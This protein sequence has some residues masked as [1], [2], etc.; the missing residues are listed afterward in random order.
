MPF[1][2]FPAAW[3][4]RFVIRFTFSIGKR[5]VKASVIQVGR[6]ELISFSDALRIL[7][8]CV[9]SMTR[10]DALGDMRSFYEWRRYTDQ[11]FHPLA[12]GLDRVT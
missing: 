5:R 1:G 4:F 7:G 11:S 6:R 2:T 9:A 10:S 3:L 12:S 8:V